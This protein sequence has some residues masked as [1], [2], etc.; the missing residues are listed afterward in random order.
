MGRFANGKGSA[1]L[2]RYKFQNIVSVRS[3]HGDDKVCSGGD[4]PRE[5]TRGKM[6]RITTKLS[7]DACRVW[8][9]RMPR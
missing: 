6:R 2:P 4:S 8:L 5:L 9:D 7:D 1:D 3:R